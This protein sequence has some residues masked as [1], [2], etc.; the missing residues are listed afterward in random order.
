M[1]LSRL[2]SLFAALPFAAQAAIVLA[3]ALLVLGA[4]TTALAAGRVAAWAQER[5]VLPRA[6]HLARRPGRWR[7]VAARRGP[8]WWIDRQ[9]Q[10][11]LREFAGDDLEEADA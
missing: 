8:R 9:A 3:L 4:V 6:V 7:V 2:F 5:R 1:T 11:L 10:V